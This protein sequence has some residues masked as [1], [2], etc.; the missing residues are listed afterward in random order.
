MSGI[1]G[2]YQSNGRPIEKPLL[3]RM[4]AQMVHRGPDGQGLW[5]DGPIGLGHA[6]LCTTPESLR[7]RQPLADRTGR[8]LLT[9]DGRVDN[10]EELRRALEAKGLILRDD[11]DAELVLAA[12]ECWGDAAPLHLIGDFAFA[13]WDGR[14]RTLFCSR[15]PLGIRP[16]YYT[17]D[18]KT[19]AFASEL[20]PLL[21]LPSVRHTPNLG[22]LGEYLSCEI[23]S[24]E[25]TLYQGILRLPP[26]HSLTLQSGRLTIARHFQIDPGHSIRYRSDG[27]YAEHF[28]AI[29]KEAVRCRLRS[30]ERVSLFLSGGVDSSSILGVAQQLTREGTAGSG[31]LDLYSIVS[32]HPAADERAYL[33]E[34]VAMWG[35]TAHTASLDRWSP[36]PLADQIGRFRD[37]PDSPNTSPWQMLYAMARQRDSRVALWGFGGDEWLTG[38][39]GHCADMLRR[40]EMRR[41]LRQIRQDLAV[42]NQWGGGGTGARDVLRW[43]LF[44]LIPS[45]IKSQI[46]RRT[47]WNVP[48]WI[49]PGFARTVGL[50]DRL[51]RRMPTPSFPT[52]AQQE[53]YG[54]MVSGWGTLDYEL[55]NRFEAHQGMEGR[56]PFC[57]RRLIEFA[58][59][60]PEEQRWRD[61]QTK[62]VLRQAMKSLLP[63]SIRRRQSKADF[64]Y[65]Y[66]DCLVQEQADQ[67]SKSLCL[68][69]EGF[70]DAGETEQL[71]RRC[72]RGDIEALGPAWMILALERWYSMTVATAT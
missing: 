30:Q 38:D 41:L 3:E 54:Q 59:A 53:A 37:F 42:S 29:F 6:R 31:E 60:I 25:D 67:A 35:M 48:R 70:V 24:L 40:F 55:C 33:D 64:S 63:D 11:T 20:R 62:F 2:L 46:K 51:L 1:V 39:S 9:L 32:S 36:V 18:G 19:F 7:E 12:Y 61:G 72:A 14:E 8:L 68:T 71:Y 28:Q 49:A 44:P 52:I 15:D 43:C 13:V 56:Y 4:L 66:R 5:I 57:D 22:M 65:L 27:D 69:R 34:A 47:L 45:S 58:F 26:S 17:F 21:D 23:T 10:R 16:F 50:Q